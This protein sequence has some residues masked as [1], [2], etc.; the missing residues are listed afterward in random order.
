MSLRYSA[1]NS[2][3]ALKVSN[4]PHHF[5]N[6]ITHTHTQWHSSTREAF[7][8]KWNN[9]SLCI[10]CGPTK[11]EI[12]KTC[13]LCQVHSELRWG[14][15]INCIHIKLN[16]PPRRCHCHGYNLYHSLLLLMLLLLQYELLEFFW[17]P[18]SAAGNSCSKSTLSEELALTKTAVM[19]ISNA[20]TTH[21]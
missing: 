6:T 4:C 9:E 16:S 3:K 19:Q 8:S 13:V 14:F 21:I 20:H 10:P 5:A 17:S 7:K 15:S 2:L 1:A 11:I 18:K 12:V